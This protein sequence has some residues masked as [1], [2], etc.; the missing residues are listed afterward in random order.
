MKM[1]VKM[2]KRYSILHCGDKGFVLSLDALFAV[3]VVLLAIAFCSSFIA[4]SR[5]RVYYLNIKKE[6]SDVFAVLDY[7][8]ILDTL[9]EQNITKE[10]QALLPSSEMKINITYSDIE[11]KNRTSFSFGASEKNF[12]V[13][14]ERFFVITNASNVTA[15]AVIRYK[16]WK[17]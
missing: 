11:L 14:G 16:T 3:F 10:M 4:E 17:K 15:F 13:S 1:K 7:A 6:A 8:K 5:E 12:V 2:K 9:N